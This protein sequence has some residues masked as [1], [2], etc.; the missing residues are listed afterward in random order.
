[1]AGHKGSAAGLAGGLH[2]DAGVLDNIT[3]GRLEIGQERERLHLAKCRVLHECHFLGQRGGFGSE[4]D[5]D[6]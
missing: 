3:E 2:V 5:L 4:A 1:M 6:L